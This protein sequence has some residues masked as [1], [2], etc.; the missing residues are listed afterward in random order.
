MNL[1]AGVHWGISRIA[2]A[3]T[4]EGTPVLAIAH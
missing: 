3:V 1:A 2:G 4:R